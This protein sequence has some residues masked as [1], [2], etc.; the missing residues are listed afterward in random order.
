[1]AG[2]PAQFPLQGRSP[3][4]HSG[5]SVTSLGPVRGPSPKAASAPSHLELLPLQLPLPA[6]LIIGSSVLLFPE[7]ISHAETPRTDVH[8]GLPS[9][10]GAGLRARSQRELGDGRGLA[11]GHTTRNPPSQDPQ[12]E[13][14]L[15][16]CPPAD[17][18]THTHARTLLP[19]SLQ[20]SLTHLHAYAYI[21]TCIHTHTLSSISLQQTHA[22]HTHTC[23]E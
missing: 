16:D 18:H 6:W 20:W 10:P 3:T 4:A 8:P 9:C 15:T 11:L 23:S 2:Q 14:A 17:P 13:Q 22:Q 19:I 7:N 21:F 12:S 5:V 1:M